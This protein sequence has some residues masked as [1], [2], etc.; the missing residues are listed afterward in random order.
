LAISETCPSGEDI[1][2]FLSC[3]PRCS[4]LPVAWVP[5]AG[6]RVPADSGAA[7]EGRF[8]QEKKL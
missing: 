6:P 7:P 5:E 8:E 3:G 4:R 1:L 2:F